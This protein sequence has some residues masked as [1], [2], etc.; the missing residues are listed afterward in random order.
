[1]LDHLMQ[2]QDGS[3]NKIDPRTVFQQIVAGIQ[4]LHNDLKMAHLNLNLS[5]ILLNKKLY[6]K[7]SDLSCLKPFENF[8]REDIRISNFESEKIYCAPELLDP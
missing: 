8:S 6:P 1:M 5:K 3:T 7:I 2:M 4:I